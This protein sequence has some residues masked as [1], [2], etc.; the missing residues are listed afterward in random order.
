MM[1]RHPW[2]VLAALLFLHVI[3]HVDRNILVGFS[4]QITAELALSNTQFGFLAGPVWVLSYGLM[5]PF[6]GSLADRYGR[7]RIMAA[8]IAVW[9]LCTAA[10]GVAHDFGQI[11]LAR[12]FVASGEAA[13][14]PAAIAL[15][16][17]VFDERRR[18]TAA[19]VFFMG[20]PIGIGLAFVLAG[21]AGTTLGW[22]GTF[23]ALGLI[24]VVVSVPLAFVRDERSKLAHVVGEP[25]LAQLGSVAAV[26]RASPRVVF[27]TTGFIMVQLIHAAFS[28]Y[29]LWLV[30][31]RGLDP[32]TIAR[33][34][35]VLQ[36]V[37]G[38][39]GAL[40]G[41]V[42][43][44]PLA[45]RLRGGHPTVLALLV[46]VGGPLMLLH[47]FVVPGGA[48]FYLGMGASFFLPLAT[49]GSALAIIQGEVPNRM[50]A[51]A[52]G[53][54]ILGVNVFA[55]AFGNLAAG[56]TSDWLTRAGYG[57]PLTAVLIG[58][59]AVVMASLAMF[60]AAARRPALR[61][62]EGEDR[63]VR[64]MLDA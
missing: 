17:D 1:K 54:A 16:G 33:Q 4:P 41:G 40:L 28:F 45:A 22:R 50:R 52:V 24:G 11:A 13:L 39:L 18:G 57:K 38:T 21:V 30:R 7:P 10:S 55:I 19:G 62:T 20:I 49:C 31:E 42:L 58:M 37:C 60:V 35:G 43:A 61:P 8:G 14:I 27:A 47:L 9:S 56:A 34:I 46:A 6:L 53:V 63:N 51:T 32:E 23:T 29:Q 59:Y 36:M 15:L 48:L 3:A 44:D 25:L 12:F 26:M 64:R 5:A 2:L